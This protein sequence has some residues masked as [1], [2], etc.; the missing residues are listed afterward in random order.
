MRIILIFIQKNIDKLW[1]YLKYVQLLAWLLQSFWIFNTLPV[2]PSSDYCTFIHAAKTPQ[3][4]PYGLIF[5]LV[6]GY[7]FSIRPSQIPSGS[8]TI[9]KILARSLHVPLS[10]RLGMLVACCYLAWFLHVFLNSYISIISP[11]FFQDLSICKVDSYPIASTA[12]RPS[13]NAL[14]VS[15]AMRSKPCRCG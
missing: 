15:P 8:L 10:F 4:A 5:F 9:W 13:R 12:M 3:I 6:L 14:P 2:Y 1:Q 11:L 7:R